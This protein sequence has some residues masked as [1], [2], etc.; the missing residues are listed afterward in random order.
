MD[1]AGVY[2]HKLGSKWLV[3]G[4][5]NTGGAVLTHLGLTAEKLQGLSA[6]IDPTTPSELDYYPL[7]KPGDIL[8]VDVARSSRH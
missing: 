2:S 1:C 8:I 3:G 6:L 7:I 4:A 5:S